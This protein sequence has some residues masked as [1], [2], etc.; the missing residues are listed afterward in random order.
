MYKRLLSIVCIVAFFVCSVPLAVSAQ[1]DETVSATTSAGT[2]DETTVV[3][4]ELVGRRQADTKYF[5]MSDGTYLAA[6]YATPV[7]FEDAAGTWQQYD[8]SLKES[9]DPTELQNTLSDKDVRLSKKAKQNKM[10]RLSI[11]DYEVA[12]GFDKINNSP[13]SV[14]E[15]AET[16]PNDPTVLTKI[17][18]EVWYRDVYPSVDLQYFVLPTGIKENIVLTDAS[19]Q[20]VF[21]QQYTLKGLTAVQLDAQTI[22]LNASD[23]TTVY[24]LSAPVMTDAESET[25][26]AVSLTITKQNG[27][28]LTVQVTAD[29]DWLQDSVRQYPV[30]VDPLITDQTYTS[31]LWNI[32]KAANGSED[33]L[34]EDSY[35]YVG[36]YNNQTARVFIDMWLP[37]I[38]TT[39]I[40]TNATLSLAYSAPSTLQSYRMDMHQVTEDWNMDTLTFNH[41][42]DEDIL[43][44]AT[45]SA[46]GTQAPTWD[47]TRAVKQW[48]FDS[49]TNHG[50]LLKAH[51]E[52]LNTFCAVV[53]EQHTDTTLC[54]LLAIRYIDGSGL[55]AYNTYKT[56]D[57]GAFGSLHVN[58]YRRNVVY[59]V[60]DVSYS[61]E[62]SGVNIYHVYNSDAY[63]ES[64]V[65]GKGWRLNLKE[66]LTCVTKNPD[67][68]DP[69][70]YHYVDATGTQIL[71][72][73]P[74]ENVINV[75]E[76]E[77]G[78]GLTLTTGSEADGDWH[79]K[80]EDK[81][82]NKKG[83]DGNG[84]L[85][86]IQDADG[87][88]ITI[89]YTGPLLT[90]V[91]DE[92][93]RTFT[94]TYTNNLLST[95]TDPEG[96]TIQYTYTD[97]RL[98]KIT[99]YTGE[100]PQYT[101][102][103]AGRLVTVLQNYFKVG[104]T[105]D[106][107]GLCTQ[108]GEYSDV[109]SG[110][111]IFLKLED[112]N[113]SVR[114][115]T[116]CGPSDDITGDDRILE[117]AVFNEYGQKITSYCTSAVGKLLG[118]LS[119]AKY[120]EQTTDKTR[121]NNKLV[122]SYST[123]GVV[124][125]YP[126]SSFEAGTALTT[127]GS[128]ATATINT[129]VEKAYIGQ[130]TARVNATS[131]IAATD[132]A[133]FRYTFTRTDT[134][135]F[136]DG[137]YVFSGYIKTE[138]LQGSAFLQA[139]VTAGG[140]T[141]VH[142]S[143]LVFDTT[144]QAVENG[145][146]RVDTRFYVPANATTVELRAG[147]AQTSV[148]T[149][150]FD[151]LQLEKS[152]VLGRYNLLQNS[153]FEQS[154]GW[155][156]T[157]IN[158]STD[159]VVVTDT[160][161]GSK[162]YQ[163]T[164]VLE[165]DKSIGQIVTVYGDKTDSYI[166]SAWVRAASLNTSAS[167]DENPRKFRL[168]CT[169]TCTDDST[170]EA[171]AK[172]FNDITT[173]WQ[174][175]SFPVK[176]DPDQGDPKSITVWI[177][178]YQNENICD[179]D[180]VQLVKDTANSY[181]YD[182]DGNLIS[183]TDRAE[184]SSDFEYA[185]NEVVKAVASTGSTYY[186]MYKDYDENTPHPHRLLSSYA[187][188]I[189]YTFQYDAHGNVT[190]TSAY[191]GNPYNSIVYW[192]RTT[193]KQDVL[194]PQ[195]GSETAGT[196]IVGGSH[197]GTTTQQ[198]K[199]YK[200]S[201]TDY[202]TIRL[203]SERS[204]TLAVQNGNV[205]LAAVSSS[206]TAQHF[207]FVQNEDG[208][209]RIVPRADET[210]VLG[211]GT[212]GLLQ[213]MAASEAQNDPAKFTLH[214]V[215]YP[216]KYITTETSY[217]TSG[218]Y[219]SVATDPRGG[220][221][222]YTY[223]EDKDELLSVTD[224]NGNVTRYEN[225]HTRNDYGTV[226]N[227]SRTYADLDG[228]GV[229]D[230]TE[231]YA[232]YETVSGQLTKVSNN[233]TTYQFG[234]NQYGNRVSMSIGGRGVTLYEYLNG[235]G[236]PYKQDYINGQNVE[237]SYDRLNRLNETLH[238]FNSQYVSTRYEYDQ[239]GNLAEIHNWADGVISRFSYDT[240]GR[241]TTAV[242]DSELDPNY[243]RY[244]RY[245]TY[246]AFNRISK[247]SFI[248]GSTSLNYRFNYNQ[249]QQLT[250]VDLP[251]DKTMSYTYDGLNRLVSQSLNTTT[252]ITRTYGYL[253]GSLGSTTTVSSLTNTQGTFTYTYDANGNITSVA[254]NGTVVES[255][256]YDALNQLTEAVVNGT[257]YTYTYDKGGNLLTAIG[258]GA[259]TYTYGDDNWKDKLTAFNGQTITY[260]GIG[261]PLQYRDGMSFTWAY[262]R[263]VHTLNTTTHTAQFNYNADGYRSQ[264]ILTDKATN[265]ATTHYYDYNGNSLICE[266]WGNNT[267]WFVYDATG[268]PL[269]L[270]YNGTPYY[271]VTNLQ[272][273]I[274]GLTN[275]VGTLI[276]QYTYDPWGK[277]L[278]VTDANGTDISA[279]ATH[280]ANINPL[281]Y[282]GY[283]YDVESGLYYL[284]SRYYDPVTQRFVNADG[285]VSTGTGILGFN[286]FAYCNNTPV[287]GVDVTGERFVE[288]AGMGGGGGAGAAANPHLLADSIVNGIKTIVSGISKLFAT[289][290]AVQAVVITTA[291][292]VTT[293][294]ARQE[295]FELRKYQREQARTQEQ[296]K[297]EVVP[298]VPQN[299]VI[300]PVDPGDFNPVGLD[301]VDREGTK[302]G[303]LVSWMDPVTN[304]EV[305][306]WDE[307]P[308]FSNGP[309]YHIHGTGHYKPGIDAV[310]EPYATIYFPIKW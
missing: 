188:G 258:N 128:G 259:K 69:Y 253:Q 290:E 94:L 191:S 200:V 135:P 75:Y 72:Y 267:M 210:K 254:K 212:N 117:Y 261:N 93:G 306:R 109:D 38:P 213:V 230:A 281:R 66:K 221:T 77:L 155:I 37:S 39:S 247:L 139:H 249:R 201:D 18:Q 2:V 90:S 156:G 218:Q 98:T 303:S 150:Y 257:T 120:T 19:A 185:N 142:T 91:T 181:E 14:V 285:Y 130:R 287:N 305:F 157:Y 29:K 85:K 220:R 87:N 194:F 116:H 111:R 95:I 143:P 147:L 163:L 50:L 42:H 127:F 141:T 44:L 298:N 271:Y 138:N 204:L 27:N 178:Y 96:R 15:P 103:N 59:T 190:R 52:S 34:W 16:D 295:Y 107:Y 277:P 250:S 252:P 144:D 145:W 136:T 286:M 275:A 172:D 187:D 239:S 140:N 154:G 1:A 104:I 266:R 282:R 106:Q 199:L 161:F 80:I 195:N 61:G 209:Y 309:H 68:S 51:D 211:M 272:G 308:N 265:T 92:S 228:D 60:S 108:L 125:L 35:A 251:N 146:R 174:H 189:T 269:G 229:R 30:T 241:L 158:P 182:D 81:Y 102:D 278:T 237:Y 206:A 274:T 208:T 197:D 283:Y 280:I 12:W 214:V 11:G 100:T 226:I 119:V 183:S 294:V 101:Y 32:A 168:R 83:F 47:I 151:C 9:D 133:G 88:K 74:N 159:K 10:I 289:T 223:D 215:S 36:K 22:A 76:D 244:E 89:G 255:Y 288:Q 279:N 129:D 21:T 70:H 55:N 193:N 225:L 152:N 5:R 53:N 79:L 224:P 167:P 71:F 256:E 284:L 123:G 268:A 8:N 307:N 3:E 219:V 46:T 124:N 148:G 242:S 64:S 115:F 62:L 240:I 262:G 56:L 99:P 180:N 114:K 304:V 97:G 216:E 293:T 65:Y 179:I 299:T 67:Y 131:A 86:I 31:E 84:T 205:V 49:S 217:T 263:R 246:D 63:N 33:F 54:P 165:Q 248:R 13:M 184:Q 291:V 121:R 234:Y 169:V 45:V 162:A 231:P 122:E 232:E 292:A 202:F 177:D 270:I 40:I 160:M 24:T 7:H 300:F 297:T 41:S 57:Y 23:G 20:N 43:D 48:Y 296:T 6:R 235:S 118:D 264:K 171:G 170:Y 186:N 233:N 134:G 245:Q 166:V 301:R 126:D 17:T 153:G 149:A 207:R 112:I 113:D 238:Y 78:L 222:Y 82:G 236:K 105:Y 176:P 243:G 173:A 26:D 164:G 4:E 198:W 276:A 132:G 58:E 28:H 227:T 302:N 196:P 73:R 110:Y 310:P 175:L 25:S 203:H 137:D 260:D 192:I 273:D